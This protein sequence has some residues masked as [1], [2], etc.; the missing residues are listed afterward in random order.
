M[1]KAVP[2]CL[3]V[4]LFVEASST[5][6]IEQQSTA[7]FKLGMTIQEVTQLFGLPGKCYVRERG[8]HRFTPIECDVAEEIYDDVRDVYTRKTKTNEYELRMEYTVDASKSRLHPELRLLSVVLVVDRPTPM[9]EIVADLPEAR[10]L[11]AGG[12]LMIGSLLGRSFTDRSGRGRPELVLYPKNPGKEELAEAANNANG[13][14]RPGDQKVL[15]DHPGDWVFALG[16]SWEDE[17][18]MEKTKDAIF[19]ENRRPATPTARDIDWVKHPI[20]EIEFKVAN[21]S[22]LKSMKAPVLGPAPAV[23]ELGEFKP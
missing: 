9:A 14:G 17:E 10:R 7:E 5:S 23:V 4:L 11:C 16:L 1:R 3:L 20:E 18:L 19:P 12:C 8:E 15:E 21:P 2:V 6:S 13:Y 22:F